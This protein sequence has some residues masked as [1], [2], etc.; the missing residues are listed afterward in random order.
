MS[1]F[2]PPPETWEYGYEIAP[3][4]LGYRVHATWGVLRDEQG[5]YAFTL[6]GAHRKG[7]RRARREQA[8]QERETHRTS[9]TI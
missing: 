5:G 1:A 7:Q 3:T 4:A 9:H 2:P 8:R 6:E